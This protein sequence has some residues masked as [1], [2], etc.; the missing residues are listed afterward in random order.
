MANKKLIT[1]EEFAAYKRSVDVQLKQLRL[2]RNIQSNQILIPSI[3]QLVLP[4]P[5]S[6][7][8]GIGMANVGVASGTLLEYG[9][10]I[11]NSADSGATVRDAN[12]RW[13]YQQTAATDG[14]FAYWRTEFYGQFRTAHAPLWIAHIKTG[15]DVSDM[16]GWFG[17]TSDDMSN[18]DD[19]AAGTQVI[20]FRYSTGVSNNWYAVTDDNA[21]LH[22]T[23]TGVAVAAD[24]VYTLMI[25]VESAAS[26]RFYINN[27]LVHTATAD[28]PASTVEF[29]WNMHWWTN[30]NVAKRIYCSRVY[31]ESN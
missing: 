1:V 22:A 16:R 28:L 25:E 7:L 2:R 19:P 4:R 15:T 24:T 18:V 9:V 29:G 3:D 11:A 14:R 13:Q 20:A 21:T 17:L 8:W 31:Q 27:A 26:V 6:R 5:D 23:D 12:T 10:D 30:E